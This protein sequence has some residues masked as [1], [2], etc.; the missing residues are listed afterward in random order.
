MRKKFSVSWKSSKK[1][2]KQRKYRAK[3]PLHIKGRFL[4]A[5]LSKELRKKYGKR[6]IRVRKGDKVRVMRGSFKKKEGAIERVD[7]KK[8]RIY[9]SKMEIE[10]KDGSKALRPIQPSNIMVLELNLD[11]KRRKKKLERK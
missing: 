1:P 3:A 6:S 5:H 8:G 2:R 11:D 10:K 7:T 4:N 9:V